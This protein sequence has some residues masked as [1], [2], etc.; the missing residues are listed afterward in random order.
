MNS[1]WFNSYHAYNDHLSFLSSLQ[2]SYPANSEIVQIGNSL[3]GKPIT[4][5]HFYGASGK[6]SKPAIVIHGTVHAREWIGTMV[7]EYFAYNLLT[8]YATN[9]EIKVSN[10]SEPIERSA[11]NA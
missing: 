8:N 3:Q 7:T 6:G 11:L 10:F 2:A 4:G 9:S 5:I 1:S